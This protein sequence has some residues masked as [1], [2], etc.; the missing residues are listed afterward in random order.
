MIGGKPKGCVVTVKDQVHELV[1]VLDDAD[2]EAV[3]SYLTRLTSKGGGA[4]V[5]EEDEDL[6]A[7]EVLRLA[8]PITE[9]DPLWNI[10]GMA[11]SG[12]DGPTD[13][14]RNKHKYL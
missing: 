2:A 7:E 8:Q 11:D 4:I 14:S 1:D 9:D 12:P 5:I 3:L 13:V 6:T 10:I